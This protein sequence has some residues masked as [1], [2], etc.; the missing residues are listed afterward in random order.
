M[1]HYLRKVRAAGLLGLLKKIVRAT[2]YYIPRL[3][4]R[5]AF[6][7]LGRRVP[8]RGYYDKTRDFL[9]HGDGRYI[10]FQSASG[11]LEPT[12]LDTFRPEIFVAIIPRARS[13]YDYGL[14]SFAGS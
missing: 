13:L 4:G 3:I 9:K 5:A 8:L 6:P 10:E 14:Y 12:L 11:S 7:V 1:R 2:R